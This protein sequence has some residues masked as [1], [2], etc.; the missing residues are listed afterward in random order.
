M[1]LENAKV[2]AERLVKEMWPHCTEVKIAGSIRRQRPEVKDIEIV[3]VP[4]GY[5]LYDWARATTNPVHWIKPGTQEIIAWQPKP[6]GKYWRGLITEP[7]TG[8]EVKLDLFLATPENFGVIY[9]IRTGPAEFSAAIM[10]Y[11]NEHQN[12]KQVKDGHLISRASGMKFAVPDE[13]TFFERIGLRHIAPEDRN[14]ERPWNQIMEA[15]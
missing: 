14:A 13:E 8:A 15:R 9:T 11:I 6:D 10:R 5:Q 1:K 12:E 3:A 2:L 7:G 4:N